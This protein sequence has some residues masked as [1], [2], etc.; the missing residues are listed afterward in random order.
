MRRWRDGASRALT[1]LRKHGSRHASLKTRQRYRGFPTRQQILGKTGIRNHYTRWPT[2]VVVVV[3]LVS[4]PIYKTLIGKDNRGRDQEEGERELFRER[5]R[6]MYR[7]NSCTGYV[8]FFLL[9]RIQRRTDLVKPILPGTT[10]RRSAR[11]KKGKRISLPPLGKRSG[12]EERSAE[13]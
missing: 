2:I 11:T 3:L 12:V 7:D 10:R 5:Y 4:W 9:P 6:H 8:K 1:S 13:A